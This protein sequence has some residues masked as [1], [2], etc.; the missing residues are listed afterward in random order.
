MLGSATL[1]I[2]LS[3]KITNSARQAA[4]RV[5]TRPRRAVGWVGMGDSF[6][7]VR[8]SGRIVQVVVFRLP[9]T[10]AGGGR[11]EWDLPAVGSTKRAAGRERPADIKWPLS[12]TVA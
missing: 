7:V 8:R 11:P 4:V 9:A 3:R 10:G 2:V 5:R 6:R 12:H 1:T